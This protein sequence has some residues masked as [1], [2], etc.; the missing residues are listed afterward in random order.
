MIRRLAATAAAVALVAAGC[1]G[2]TT[3]AAG[4]D[5][6]DALR[7]DVSQEAVDQ[8]LLANPECREASPIAIERADD[9]ART[10]AVA[11]GI[12][13]DQVIEVTCV[14]E[15]AA[16]ITIVAGCRNGLWLERTRVG[17]W[18]RTNAAC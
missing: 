10:S 13:G 7:D 5:D 14:F 3:P 2:S 11:T 12:A 9:E 4:E 1:G 17:S 6:V 16:N 18:S 8:L 15:D